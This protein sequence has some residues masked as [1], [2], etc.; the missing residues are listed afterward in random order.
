MQR[1]YG[2]DLNEALFGD[3][4]LSARRLVALVRNLPP[5]SALHRRPGAESTEAVAESR[6]EA[7]VLRGMAL[8]QWLAGTA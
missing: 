8:K 1:F 3:Q 4:P 2:L 7:P 5:E 6:E